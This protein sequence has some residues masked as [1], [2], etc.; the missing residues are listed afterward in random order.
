LEL[1]LVDNDES[2]A[3]DLEETFPEVAWRVAPDEIAAAEIAGR[4]VLDGV[5]IELGARAG[6]RL[7]EQLEA[8]VLV[9]ADDLR[10]A[11]VIEAQRRGVELSVKSHAK[12]AVEAFCRRLR[13]SERHQ[14]REL[15]AA[16]GLTVQEHRVLELHARGLDQP[17]IAAALGITKRTVRAHLAAVRRKCRVLSSADLRGL[18]ARES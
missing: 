10:L 1:M 13:T 8:P 17:V 18:V 3:R 11:L 2:F 15:A 9:L 7:V 12:V 4:A 16:H 14:V 6:W 5:V